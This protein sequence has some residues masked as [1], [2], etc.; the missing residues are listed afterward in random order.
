MLLRN[1]PLLSRAGFHTWPPVWT[2]ISGKENKRP[3]GEVGTLKAVTL[4]DIQ[5]PD[6]CFLYIDYDESSYIG[7]LLIDDRTF[8][9]NIVKI[10]ERHLN[11]SIADIGGLDISHTL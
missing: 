8:C 5:P 2:F 3:R 11:H 4:S 7:C 6:R 9:A 10:L 1:H